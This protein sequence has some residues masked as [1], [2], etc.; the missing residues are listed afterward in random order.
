MSPTVPSRRERPKVTALQSMK[1]SGSAACSPSARVSSFATR[2]ADRSPPAARMR[3]S[4]AGQ[5][6]H[7]RREFLAARRLGVSQVLPGKVELPAA[8]WVVVVAHRA[9]TRIDG[10]PVASARATS[11]RP[12][13]PDPRG[14]RAPRLR[15]WSGGGPRA[16]RCRRRSTGR[17]L[18]LWPRDRAARRAGCRGRR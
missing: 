17:S 2:A 18:G 10:S 6:P 8:R 3:M 5:P 15:P 12:G 7:A 16:E 13:P 11:R 9:R 1:A 4:H 14:S